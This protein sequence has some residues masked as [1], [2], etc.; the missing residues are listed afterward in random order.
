M[1]TPHMFFSPSQAQEFIRAG[2]LK[3]VVDGELARKTYLFDEV[4]KPQ[5]KIRKTGEWIAIPSPA[6]PEDWF[7][8][9]CDVLQFT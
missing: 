6:A 9:T 4:S 3:W 8:P 7:G 2:R 5:N 1:T